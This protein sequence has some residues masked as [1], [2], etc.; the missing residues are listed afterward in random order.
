MGPRVSPDVFPLGEGSTLLE[1]EIDLVA[2]TF[3][4]EE[5]SIAT[6][7]N[8]VIGVAVPG[9][10]EH[11][12]G[13]MHGREGFALHVLDTFVHEEGGITAIIDEDIG[14][15]VLRPGEHLAGHV[16]VLFE[17]LV[18]PGEDVG[19]GGLGDGS[20]GMVLGGVELARAIFS[21]LNELYGNVACTMGAKWQAGRHE[22]IIANGPAGSPLPTGN[23]PTDKCPWYY[24][25]KDW[26]EAVVTADP[27]T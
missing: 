21:Q 1:L 13:P 22:G 8:E 23:D 3:V 7:I 9:P 14:T 2:E 15:G 27:V 4:H 6:I 16:I 24:R 11:L 18:L 5:V 26:N 12:A 10:G 20:G 25:P 19:S 17:G